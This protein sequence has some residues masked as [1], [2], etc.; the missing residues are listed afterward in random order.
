[1]VL[2]EDKQN[3]YTFKKTH[4]ENQGKDSNQYS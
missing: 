2:G 3:W 1:M 4:H